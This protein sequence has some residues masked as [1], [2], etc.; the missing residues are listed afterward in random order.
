MR[1]NKYESKERKKKGKKSSKKKK[2]KK[3]KII[4]IGRV[5]WRREKKKKRDTERESY[6]EKECSFFVYMRPCKTFSIHAL[7]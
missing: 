2:R 4:S 7:M 5:W 1:I 6:R 3:E